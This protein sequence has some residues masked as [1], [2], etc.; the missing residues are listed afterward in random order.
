M[1]KLSQE[2]A[3]YESM[4]AELEADCFGKW[5]LVHD[6]ELTGVYTA[7][8]Q[9]AEDAVRKFGRGPF[10]IRQVGQPPLVLPASVVY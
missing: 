4:R 8:E 10:L 9:A 2:I 3:A 1:A 6:E 5:V 7:F